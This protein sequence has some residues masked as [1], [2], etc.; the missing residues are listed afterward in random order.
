[1]FVVVTSSEIYV[2]LHFSIV[3]LACDRALELGLRLSIKSL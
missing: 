2:G 1:M 3:I